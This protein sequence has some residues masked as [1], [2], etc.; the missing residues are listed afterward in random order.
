MPFWAPDDV[1]D[2]VVKDARVTLVFARILYASNEQSETVA[3]KAMNTLTGLFL[4]RLGRK[5]MG[6]EEFAGAFIGEC[7]KDG[8]TV[9]ISNDPFFKLSGYKTVV[10]DWQE[11]SIRFV[12]LGRGTREEEVFFTTNLP[13]LKKNS[14][15]YLARQLEKE[16]RYRDIIGEGGRRE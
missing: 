6:G 13:K 9:E 5:G 14:D 10:V 12:E 1:L 11:K 3:Q 15:G 4:E 2:L 7:Y 8:L 16:S